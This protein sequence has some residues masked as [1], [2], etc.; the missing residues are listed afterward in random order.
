MP[1]LTYVE[2]HDATGGVCCCCG[3]LGGVDGAGQRDARLLPA[4][5]RDPA[6]ADGRQLPVRQQRQVD[7]EGAR[8]PGAISQC[9][10][11]AK[12]Q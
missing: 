7:R 8:L 1:P 2:Q 4:A 6:L 10:R 11:G 3:E 12:V 9:V 5:E